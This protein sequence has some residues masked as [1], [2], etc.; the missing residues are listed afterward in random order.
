MP[1]ESLKLEIMKRTVFSL[2]LLMMAMV[3]QADG[4]EELKLQANILDKTC[5]VEI[6]AFTTMIGVECGEQ[7]FIYYYIVSDEIVDMVLESPEMKDV[8]KSNME[9]ILSQQ[10]EEASF[11]EFISILIEENMGIKYVYKKQRGEGEFFVRCSPE[12]LRE[13]LKK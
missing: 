11:K 8:L 10:L 2:L 9:A 4:R 5:P 6:D 12:E 1:K 7:D 3:A 13:M